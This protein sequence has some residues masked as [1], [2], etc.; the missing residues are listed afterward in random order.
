M[1]ALVAQLIDQA[2]LAIVNLQIIGRE[3]VVQSE[4]LAGIGA[5][6]CTDKVVCK[7]ANDDGEGQGE[8]KER[9]GGGPDRGPQV[10]LFASIKGT[11]AAQVLA[12]EIL[13]AVDAFDLL[14]PGAAQG[15]GARGE[16]HRCGQWRRGEMRL[17]RVW[18]PGG[19]CLPGPWRSDRRPD[20]KRW[21]G[22]RLRL[23]GYER[24]GRT[25][26]DVLDVRAERS[27]CVRGWQRDFVGCWLCIRGRDG[28]GR[29]SF[30]GWSARGFRRAPLL[31]GGSGWLCGYELLIVLIEGE[32][33]CDARMRRERFCNAR[34]CCERGSLAHA[35][36]FAAMGVARS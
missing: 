29:G 30:R 16:S 3:Q 7:R 4:N 6:G 35:R 34:L 15:R 10:A 18:E 12:R 14:S 1:D 13:Q 21:I 17:S 33:S 2:P 36:A 27:H 31:Q 5:P 8:Q 25:A 23:D 22:S 26:R 19:R 28:F 32:R 24:R 9:R 20:W 11:R